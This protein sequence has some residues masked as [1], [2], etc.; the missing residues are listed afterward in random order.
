MVAMPD[1]LTAYPHAKEALTP[2]G[3]AEAI[4]TSR[5]KSDCARLQFGRELIEREQGP[6]RFAPRR[7]NDYLAE[8][9][10]AEEY[11]G[12]VSV[13]PICLQRPDIHLVFDNA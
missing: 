5:A 7:E 13:K 8:P 4:A 11:D 2:H 9:G 1:V 10:Q 6:R 12:C 3:P